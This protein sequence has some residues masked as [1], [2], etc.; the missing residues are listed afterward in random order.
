MKDRLTTLVLMMALAA[1]MLGISALQRVQAEEHDSNAEHCI[2]LTNIDRT[3]VVGDYGILFYMLD[4]DIYLN[5]LPHRC[6]GLGMDKAFM[7]RSSVGQLC[8]LDIIS[9]LD[10][11][12][13]GLRPGV[14]C[15]LGM[16][17]PVSEDEAKALASGE[18]QIEHE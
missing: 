18:K 5:K 16:F 4:D 14:S 11:M 6:P 15:G 9:L 13:F 1:T 2:R 10:D 7:Y 12:G 17:H 3:E 8:D